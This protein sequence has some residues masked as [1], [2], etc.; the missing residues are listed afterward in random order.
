MTVQDAGVRG[1]RMA[2]EYLRRLGYA[3]LARRYRGGDGEIDLVMRDGSCL[4]FVEVKYRPRS[5]AG[6]G[7]SAVTP[8]KRRRMIHA[9]AAFLTEREQWG[10]PVRFDVVEITGA[11]LRHVP[12]AFPAQTEYR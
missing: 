11:G 5:Q 12:N 9:A 8:A 6:E 7:L 4:V 10:L 1:E 3:L 2:E